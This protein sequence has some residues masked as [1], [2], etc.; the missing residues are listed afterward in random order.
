MVTASRDGPTGLWRRGDS[1]SISLRLESATRTL[2]DDANGDVRGAGIAPATDLRESFFVWSGSIE[3]PACA[4]GVTGLE[5]FC[6]LSTDS[7]GT[8]IAVFSGGGSNCVAA[9]AA[10]AA[11]SEDFKVLLTI[12]DGEFSM[13]RSTELCRG[14]DV[15]TM[16]SSG[17]H[18]RK[19]FPFACSGRDLLR[20]MCGEM[21]DALP[22]DDGKGVCT[23]G[24]N[25]DLGR[26][27]SF[28]PVLR[29]PLEQGIECSESSSSSEAGTSS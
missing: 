5:T 7:I 25:L 11:T 29:L 9:V 28:S 1:S 15:P 12:L 14:F 4:K 19:F 16:L 10:V 6:L 22:R 2:K 18:C 27:I 21:K 13:K 3:T 24:R 17:G 8:E 23:F 26:W 20:F